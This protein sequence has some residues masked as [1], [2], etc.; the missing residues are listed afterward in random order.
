MN[1]KKNFFTLL[2]IFVV[3]LVMVVL[4]NNLDILES[5]NRPFENLEINQVE[6][7]SPAGSLNFSRKEE[8]WGLENIEYKVDEQ[9]VNNIITGIKNIDLN[10]IIST[11][12]DRYSQLGVTRERGNRVKFITSGGK[13]TIFY[14][15]KNRSDPTRSYF[16]IKESTPVYLVK[17]LEPGFYNVK[18]K[19][20]LKEKFF[21]EK[22]ENVKDITV[23]KGNRKFEISSSSTAVERLVNYLN[24]IKA[25]EFVEITGPKIPDFKNPEI[26][27]NFVISGETENYK[28][29]EEEKVYVKYNDLIYQI[30]ESYFKRLKK[31]IEEI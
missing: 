18:K 10:N 21:N 26:N 1:S 2:I 3:L 22:P 28:I 17:G 5:S 31:I 6:L 16:R 24:E 23:E 25:V 11:K 29:V 4:K 19:Y 13:E 14:I 8:G 9:K 20:W 30:R 12:V 15:S 7:K 27:I